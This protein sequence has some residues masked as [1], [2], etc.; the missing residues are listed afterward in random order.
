MSPRASLDLFIATLRDLAMAA[1]RGETERF[2]AAPYHA[3]RRRMDE[4][5]AARQP[6]LRW[7]PP[8]PIKDA[9]E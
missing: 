7:T 6:I 4:T 3:P 5:K 9:A 2:S 1:Q 8:E